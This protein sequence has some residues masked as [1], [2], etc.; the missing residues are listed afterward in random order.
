MYV[1]LANSF[2]SLLNRSAIVDLFLIFI[3]VTCW[4]MWQC[5]AAKQ[6]CDKQQN[7]LDGSD[8]EMCFHHGEAPFI[9][10]PRDTLFPPA[11]IHMDGKGDFSMTPLAS[12]SLCPHTHF[13]CPGQSLSTHPLLVSR[14]VSLCVNTPT[15]CVQVSLCVSTHPL[16]V[17]RSVSVSTHPLLVS[18]SVSLSVH[19]PTS[20]VQVSLCPHT[21]FLCPGQS[22]STHPLLVSRS[23][24]LPLSLFM[25]QGLAGS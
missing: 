1:L 21:H 12:F 17:S 11:V 3:T 18:R 4:C 19:T 6:I 23:V 2:D 10:F 8:E 24:S 9:V 25:S 14:S 22:L 5:M 20:C 13:L 16:L 7:C 15:S